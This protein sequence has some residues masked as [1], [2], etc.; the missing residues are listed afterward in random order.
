MSNNFYIGI[1]FGTTYSV[2]SYLE[3][4]SN[5]NPIVVPNNLGDTLIPS[6]I[7]VTKDLKFRFGSEANTIKEGDIKIEGIK[8]LLG[9]SYNELMTDIDLDLLPYEIVEDELTG[10]A[11]IKVQN[12]TFFPQELVAMFLKK[13]IPEVENYINHKI[14]KAIFTIPAIFNESQKNALIEAANSAGIE[15][16]KTLLEPTAAAIFYGYNNIKF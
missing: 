2:I 16:E 9:K 8:R 14:T 13:I 3:N 12:K 7:V 11:K 5:K 15:V 1:D 4:G 6:T 10:K